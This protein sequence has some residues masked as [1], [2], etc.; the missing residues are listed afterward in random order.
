GV[1]V[2]GDLID[3]GTNYPAAKYANGSWTFIDIPGRT[4]A[5]GIIGFYGGGG[6]DLEL[7]LSHPSVPGKQEIWYQL[8]NGT[9]ELKADVNG[10]VNDIASD[11]IGRVY[12]GQFDTLTYYT[13]SVTTE[14]P[15][16]N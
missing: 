8:T 16:H 5:T 11:Q 10:L 7:V 2:F 15:A 4:G 1:F 3:N 13:A 6:Y 12:V 9:W 14:M